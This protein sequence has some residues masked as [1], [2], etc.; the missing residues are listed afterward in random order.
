MRRNDLQ[1]FSRRQEKDWRP[2]AFAREDASREGHFPL[3]L[4]FEF[5]SAE[6]EVLP[7]EPEVPDDAP[8]LEPV[9]PVLPELSLGDAA[10]LDEVS[11]L[12][13]PS[14]LVLPEGE[15]AVLLPLRPCGR[16]DELDPLVP[17]PVDDAVSD[18]DVPDD[19]LVLPCD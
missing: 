17:V 15:R 4:E 3:E 7:V 18:P 10:E 13:E 9:V 14:P 2:D 8:V 11:E 1:P 5:W 16:L 12:P 19:L 6:F